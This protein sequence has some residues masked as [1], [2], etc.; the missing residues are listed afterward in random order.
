M[1]QN[2]TIDSTQ[3]TSPSLLPFPPHITPMKHLVH[4]IPLQPKQHQPPHD[5]LHPSTYPAPIY[6]SHHRFPTR[7][8]T[9]PAQLCP[10]RAESAADQLPR[11]AERVPPSAER[12]PNRAVWPA[13]RRAAPP[14]SRSASGRAGRRG[15]AAAAGRRCTC[16]SRLAPAWH[17]QTA[18]GE[19]G[20]N[21]SEVLIT[22]N[23]PQS[24]T[25]VI[26]VGRSLFHIFSLNRE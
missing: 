26:F 13:D 3:K 10:H 1:L 6:A 7:S 23:I 17:R 4:V 15:T 11:N 12:V 9:P 16:K 5:N 24:V 19:G 25:V 8:L 21:L 18:S 14:N 22:C 20:A 2:W